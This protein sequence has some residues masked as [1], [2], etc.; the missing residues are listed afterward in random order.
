MNGS[1]GS[2]VSCGCAGTSPGLQRAGCMGGASLL[3]ARERESADHALI[4]SR[5]DPTDS[6]DCLRGVN[7]PV[8]AANKY[9]QLR[10]FR[11]CAKFPQ[12]ARHRCYA[13]FGKTLTVVTDGRFAPV[14]VPEAQRAGCPRGLRRRCSARRRGARHVL[15]SA[16]RSRARAASPG[17]SD[18]R[19]RASGAAVRDLGA[20]ARSASSRSGRHDVVN[21]VAGAA[22]RRIAGG[23]GAHRQPFGW[24]RQRRR[25]PSTAATP[26]C[27]PMTE[28]PRRRANDH[29]ASQRLERR[30]AKLGRELCHRCL[31]L[32]AVGAAPEVRVE[33]PA[34]R[35]ATA[36]RRARSETCARTRFT[37][38]RAYGTTPHVP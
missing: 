38:Y 24:Q 9:E 12:H 16:R 37:D 29:R 6:L 1:E 34:A 3:M 14:G 32:S 5:L 7:V 21:S 13:W 33:H 19:L 17:G 28:N 15:L 4:C 20:S 31:E 30:R 11:T 35:A 22:E 18:G 36:R 8:V 23:P 26:T 25:A 2:T 10:L 27:A